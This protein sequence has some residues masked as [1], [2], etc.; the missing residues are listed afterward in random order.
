MNPDMFVI[1][2]AAIVHATLQLGIGALLLLYHSSLGKH[3][4]KK[5][6]QLATN[7]I[8]GNI[9]LT[10]L[11]VAAMCFGVDIVFQGPMNPAMLT[12]I[13]MLLAAL[14][15]SIWTFYYR[16]GKSTE[17]W[18]PK[19]VA[20]YIDN[21]AKATNSNTEAFGLGMLACFAE[22]PFTF[23]L[24]TVAANSIISLSEGL[25]ILY[26]VI[27]SVIS[28]LP[29]AILRIAIRRGDTTAEI[30]KWR[31]RNKTFLRIVSGTGFLVL[32]LFILAFKVIGG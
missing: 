26:L 30:Q 14:A 25:Q 6:R 32:G 29:L 3:V 9:L 27:Y 21:R 24:I 20:R 31:I 7:Y 18:L 11:A 16:W 12:I 2:L 13:T 4:R 8:F 10:A 19:S 17:L 22:A 23:I 28:I 5:T 15:V 1:L